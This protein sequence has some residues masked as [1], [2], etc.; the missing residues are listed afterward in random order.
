M[1]LSLDI[2]SQACEKHIETR[3]QA[4]QQFRSWSI[5]QPCNVSVH[6]VLSDKDRAR[7]P[8]LVAFF[9]KSPN[10]LILTFHFSRLDQTWLPIAVV[11]FIYWNKAQKTF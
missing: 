11:P 7:D 1:L 3:F 9:I 8:I 4:L 2:L 6:R 5:T 10:F